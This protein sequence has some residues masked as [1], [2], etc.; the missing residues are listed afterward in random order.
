M[1]EAEFQF[2]GTGGS[3]GVP[4]VGCDCVVCRSDSSFNKRLRSSGLMKI[5]SKNFLIDCGPDFRQQ[6][7][8]Y[9]IQDLEGVLFTHAHYD[10]IASI[11]ELRVYQIKNRNPI[12]W[13]LSS[14]TEKEIY[15]RFSYV[16]EEPDIPNKVLPKM[17]M[18]ILSS[19]RGK[20]D[21]QG[22]QIS[23]FSF[24]QNKTK[25][26]GYR[27]GNFAYVTDIKEYPESI[28]ADLKG[29]DQL[30][31]SALRFTH[32]HMHFTVDEAV[33][34]GSKVGAKQVWLMHIA[35]EL[36]HDKVNAYLPNNVQLAY[37]GLKIQF[38]AELSNE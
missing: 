36:D 13:L 33:A 7:L 5:G 31:L 11:D 37:D 32:S 17:E 9:Q 4:V 35:H 25:V 10:H 23:Y 22:L 15:H 3:L 24:L 1:S 30:V 34:F 12:A 20:I 8:L 27:C 16:F 29:V 28:F 38:E 2:L 6:A 14:E 26:N 21:F 19:D 18:E